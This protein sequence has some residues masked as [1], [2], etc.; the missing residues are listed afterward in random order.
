M[1]VD[2]TTLAIFGLIAWALFLLVGI[3]LMRTGATLTQGR[4]ANS[5]SPN[6]DDLSPFSGRLCRA[7]ANCC[8]LLPFA[9]A[10]M[11]YGVA[12]DQTGVTNGLAL[13]LLG[14][15]LGQSIVHIISTS[16]LAVLLR[17]ALFLPQVAI[18]LYWAT[19]FIGL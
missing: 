12:T 4:A 10:A 19:K 15:R 5:F 18:V 3:A 1:E 6:G 13:V 8:E 16:S 7:Y 14:A 2:N 9:L 11:L 17:F